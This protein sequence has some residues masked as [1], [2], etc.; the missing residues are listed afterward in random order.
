MIDFNPTLVQL[1]LLDGEV[2]VIQCKKFQSHIGAIRI[3]EIVR[4]V[5]KNIMVFQSHIGAIRIVTRV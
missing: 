5:K 4:T 3:E 2:V 1:E